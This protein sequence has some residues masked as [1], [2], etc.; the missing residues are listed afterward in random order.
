MTLL[1]NS[2]T[3]FDTSGRN[4]FNLA[5]LIEK[6]GKDKF[7]FGTHFPI[8]DYLTG[9]LRIASLWENEA[10]RVTKEMRLS[11]NAS[12]MPGG[13]YLSILYFILL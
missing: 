4:I 3:L 6:Y 7:A 13:K 5:D 10:D 12:T 2:K 11:G 1:K 8:L 9:L